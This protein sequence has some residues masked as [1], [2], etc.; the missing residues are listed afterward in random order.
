MSRVKEKFTGSVA[1]KASKGGG[2][3]EVAG[4]LSS[5]RPEAESNRASRNLDAARS[6]RPHCS[7]ADSM[8]PRA[9]D[10]KRGS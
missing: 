4:R 6:S 10:F 5:K 9:E 8:E 2:G 7:E 3:S 1:S